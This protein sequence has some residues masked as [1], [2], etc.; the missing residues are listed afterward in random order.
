M[1]SIPRVGQEVIIDF[2]EGDTDQP[3]CVGCVYNPDQMPM[4]K[5]PDEKTKTYYRS[6][7]SPGGSGYN[8]LRY[9]DKAGQEQTYFHAMRN[10]DE[11]V[12]NDSMERVGNDRHPLR[13]GLLVPPFDRRNTAAN[14]PVSSRSTSP[15]KC[16]ARSPRAR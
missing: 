5:L 14:S 11:R 10:M 1:L 6:N 4:Y 13:L 7:S 16:R 12:R 9:E 3:V 2:L 15:I 8:E